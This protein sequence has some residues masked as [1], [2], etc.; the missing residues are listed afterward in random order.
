MPRDRRRDTP[1]TVMEAARR[2]RHA[3]AELASFSAD[4]RHRALLAVARAIEEHAAQILAANARD[5]D[6]AGEL[7]A[8]GTM[9]DALFRRLRLDESKLRDLL[10]GIEQVAAL[11]DPVG[12]ITLA[13]ELD[14]GLRLER[15]TCPIGVIGVVFESRPDVLPQIAS[16]CLKSGNA[17]LLKGGSEAEHSNRMLARVIQEAESSAGVPDGALTLLET[18][19]DVA[20]LLGADRD[21]DLLIP[22]GSTA[23]VR[24]MQENTR[25]PVLGHA[26][27]VCHVYVDRAADLEKAL[28]IVLDAKVQYPAACN[29]VEAL[30]VHEDV[31]A[32]F[33]P[34]VIAALRRRSVEVRCDGRALGLAG[35]ADVRAATQA[36]WGT[37]F[38]DLVLAVRV[39]ESLDAAIRHVNTHGSRH[40]D[41]IVTEDPEAAERF[42][43]QVDAAGV[44]VNVSTRFADGYRYGFGAEVGISTG[45]LHPRGPVGID[46]LVTYKYR[47][48]G[49]GHVV[50]T[51]VGPEAK[52]FRHRELPL[53]DVVTSN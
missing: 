20:A 36:D 2:A 10:A 49:D 15:V 5:L 7:V 1:G 18:R 19:E 43:A 14:D 9:S 37:E 50:A 24:H 25:I 8:A 42:V 44:F 41:A 3:A 11:P 30:L 27:G 47:L 28:A 12:R 48:I 22:R 39:V 35:T 34:V 13:T 51:Y 23:L 53:E 29:A 32:E 45:K 46:G 38:G 31:A 21:V 4:A 6:A 16:L 26:E 40:T 17:V 52:G 33:L